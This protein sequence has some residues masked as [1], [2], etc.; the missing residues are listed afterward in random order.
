MKTVDWCKALTVAAVFAVGVG[1]QTI[2]NGGTDAAGV[3]TLWFRNGTFKIKTAEEL[4]GLAYLVNKNPGNKDMNGITITLGANI[5]LND[6]SN[7]ENWGPEN[8]KANRWQAIGADTARAFRGTFDGAGFVISGIYIDTALNNQGLF[9]CVRD[10]TLKNVRVAASYIRGDST[11][12][13]A[14]VGKNIRGTIKNTFATGNVY[15]KDSVGGLVGFS[16]GTLEECYATGA[17]V[18]RSNVGG[19]VGA[20]A[21]VVPSTGIGAVTGTGAVRTCYAVGSVSGT[22]NVGGLVGYS[23]RDTIKN[24]YAT[25]NVT[26]AAGYIGGLVGR[27][28]GYRIINSCA[29]GNVGSV[30]SSF[31]GGLVGLDSSAII[32]NSYA[33]GA[34]SGKDNF[35]GL[36]G[37]I[38]IKAAIVCGYYNDS[39]GASKMLGGIHKT[40]KDMRDTVFIQLLNAGAYALSAKKW[41]LSMDGYPMLSNETVSE[42]DFYACFAE[43]NSTQDRP[44]IIKTRAHLE[45]LSAAVNC[46]AGLK[47]KYLALG[48]NIPLGGVVE[49]TPIGQR[50]ESDADSMFKGTFDGAAFT[51]SGVYIDRSR[52]QDADS[53]QG[54][55]GRIGSGGLVKN[56]RVTGVKIQGYYHVGGLAGLNRG[57]ISNCYVDGQ[58]YGIGGISGGGEV[59]GLVGRND[60]AVITNSNT[61]VEINGTANMVGGLVGWNSSASRIEY[62][63]AQSKVTG[64]GGEDLGGL[65]GRND[66]STVENSYAIGNVKG[67]STNN[68]IGGLVGINY[69]AKV[70]NCYAV[71]VVSGNSSLGGLVGLNWG[72]NNTITSCYYNRDTLEAGGSYGIAKTTIEMKN[73]VTYIG[74]NFDSCWSV[75]ANINQGYPHI[76]YGIKAS[77][78]VLSAQ[79]TGGTVG[80]NS[81]FTLSVTASVDPVNGGKLSYEWYS[82]KSENYDGA[83]KID[84]VTGTSY[85]VPT[86]EIGTLYYYVIVTNTITD[87]GDGG[88]KTASIT[89]RTAAVT[90]SPDISILSQE[91]EVPSVSVQEA[92][93]IIS[94]V[95]ALPVGLTVGPNPAVGHDGAVGIY[96]QGGRIASAA[97]SIYDASGNIV[98]KL[99][100]ADPSLHGKRKVGSWNLKDADGRK[101]PPGTYLVKGALKTSNGNSEKISI[102]INVR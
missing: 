49:W 61:S 60:S 57:T 89:S 92:A 80:L 33:A 39:S 83:K 11:C 31:V 22:E 96:R 97:L 99:E 7:W 14:L 19:L 41:I 66:G 101:V 58:V 85:K 28:D 98:N 56:L 65:V 23:F 42:S 29:T 63:Y 87:N 32:K 30:N 27:S 69:N 21:A 78:P 84:G 102:L 94:P 100:V 4:A 38:S 18:G 24:S 90:V 59:G 86:S 76:A 12:V 43:G 48:G 51:V 2:W 16:N 93:A 46:G 82:N 53:Y 36:V 67:D 10:G 91:R 50:W 62:C 79:L 68:G 34:V 52:P 81:A 95:G 64:I 3:D 45:N 20:N 8:E 26:G 5:A 44:L 6:I 35:G 73:P 55:F 74:W 54:L 17:V 40:A 15:G 70:I 71:G 88:I 37:D 9:G 72:T 13:G 77:K 47:G 1:A 25:G 75:A